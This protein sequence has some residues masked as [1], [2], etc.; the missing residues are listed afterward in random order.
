MAGDQ[1]IAGIL[2]RRHGRQQQAR[3]QSRRHILQAVNSQIDLT[4]QQGVLDLFDEDA[5]AADDG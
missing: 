4:T 5:L 3:L 1:G 2:A